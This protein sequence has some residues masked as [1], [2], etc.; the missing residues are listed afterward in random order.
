VLFLN[1]ETTRRRPRNQRGLTGQ[2]ASVFLNNETIHA[3]F[4]CTE[5]L[6]VCDSTRIYRVVSEH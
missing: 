2:H 1:T 3:L 6:D 5:I 4:L